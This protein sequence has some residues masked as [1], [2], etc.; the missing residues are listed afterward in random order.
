M[1]RIEKIKI[2]YILQLI[3]K[4]RKKIKKDILEASSVTLICVIH[5][6]CNV[7]SVREKINEL[8]RSGSAATIVSYT[9]ARFYALHPSLPQMPHSHFPSLPVLCLLHSQTRQNASYHHFPFIPRTH[10]HSYMPP[11][12]S[13]HILSLL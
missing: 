9:G 5:V 8:E 1:R 13:L 7:V 10:T 3:I 6:I 2:N 4:L 11:S 12:L